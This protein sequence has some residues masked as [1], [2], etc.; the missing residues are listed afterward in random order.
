MRRTPLQF[1][2]LCWSSVEDVTVCGC[3]SLCLAQKLMTC[4]LRQRHV[5]QAPTRSKP[6]KQLR[7]WRAD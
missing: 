5:G 3:L 7:K 6:D 4:P 1:V 2:T